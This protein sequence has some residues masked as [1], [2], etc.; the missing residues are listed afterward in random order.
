MRLFRSPLSG[1]VYAVSRFKD[2]GDGTVVVVGKTYDVTEDFRGL[3]L[4]NELIAALQPFA[5]FACNE[6]CQCHNCRARDVIAR[7]KAI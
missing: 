4:T 7:A 5:N 1:H 6:P 2:V 3:S